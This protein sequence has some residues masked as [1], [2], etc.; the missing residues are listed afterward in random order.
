MYVALLW[1][2]PTSEPILAVGSAWDELSH[3]VSNCDESCILSIY[4]LVTKF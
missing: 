2:L 3:P 1:A 4:V